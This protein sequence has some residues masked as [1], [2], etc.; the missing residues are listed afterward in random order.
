ML[1]YTM[2]GVD[3]GTIINYILEKGGRGWRNTLLVTP[4]RG[5]QEF[6]DRVKQLERQL[7]DESNQS[8]LL[9]DIEQRL[10]R[11]E[12]HKKPQVNAIEPQLEEEEIPV[13]AFTP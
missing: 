11:I 1:E 4:V 5:L 9:H 12:G 7:M 6:K 3:F 13:N 2:Q 8:R 10:K